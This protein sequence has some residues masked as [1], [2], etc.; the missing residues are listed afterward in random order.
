[1][2]LR[3]LIGFLEW[4]VAMSDIDGERSKNCTSRQ[5]PR[6]LVLIWK[7]KG[8]GGEGLVGKR[9]WVYLR[10]LIGLFERRVAVH[11]IDGEMTK[12]FTGPQILGCS[13]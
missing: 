2:Y 12:N 11:G 1:M 6:C 10:Q 3:Q 7:V 5:T 9:G 8:G 13:V 4:G